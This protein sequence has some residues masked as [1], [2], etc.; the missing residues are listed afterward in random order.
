MFRIHGGAPQ[1][2]PRVALADLKERADDIDVVKQ[3][4]NY[5]FEKDVFLEELRINR[6]DML[7]KYQA[8]I[9]GRSIQQ[10]ADITI[11]FIQEYETYKAL[12]YY[13]V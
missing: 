7:V 6:R 9:E 11:E 12:H 2:R 3:C 5:K 4:F 10:I 1:K 13:T 8:R